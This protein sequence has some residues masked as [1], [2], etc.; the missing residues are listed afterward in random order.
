MF[1]DEAAAGG[2][3]EATGMLAEHDERRYETQ[4]R[5]ARRL[6][7][8]G[9]LTAGLTTREAT[10][11]IW[12]IASERTYLALVGSR[13]WTPRRYERWLVRQLSAALL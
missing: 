11:M 5:L 2:D 9:H 12:T 8:R 7:R 13:G 3:P 6:H 10:D 1:A 4:S